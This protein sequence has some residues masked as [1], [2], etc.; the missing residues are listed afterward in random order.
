MP[1]KSIT[2]TCGLRRT[3]IIIDGTNHLDTD[4]KHILI[5]APNGPVKVP[6]SVPT[7]TDS[8]PI[9]TTIAKVTWIRAMARHGFLEDIS[10]DI[11]LR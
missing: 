1:L 7:P 5:K 4:E 10:S 9:M 8:L 6:E 3:F 11:G 2:D